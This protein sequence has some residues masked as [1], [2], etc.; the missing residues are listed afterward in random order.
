MLNGVRLLR[1][2]VRKILLLSA[3]LVIAL[4][5]LV[6]AGRETIDE[7]DRYRSSINSYA[8]TLLGLGLDSQELQ[9]EW[10]QLT[11]R[12][13][14]KDLSIYG[15]DQQKPAIT[16]DYVTLDLDLIQSV[17]SRH[18]VWRELQLGRVNLTAREDAEG[19]WTIAGLPLSGSGD[20]SGLLDV[21]F[22][23]AYLEIELVSLSLVFF[24]GTEEVLEARNILLE[25]SGGFH[26]LLAAVNLAGTE[27][28]AELIVEGRGDRRDFKNF[29]G[30]GYLKLNRIDFSGS[31]NAL[32]KGWFP[33][34]VERIGNIET[35]IKGEVW[36]NLVEGGKANLVGRISAAEVPLNWLED[37]AP[38]TNFKTEMTGWFHL[39][40]DWGLRLQGLDFDWDE[41]KIEPLD[42]NFRQAVGA[43][44]DNGSLAVSQINLSLLDDLLVKA[45][46]APDAIVDIVQQLQPMGNINS[47]HLDLSL[48]NETPDVQMRANLDNVSVSSWRGA[49]AIRH[50][51]GY[52]EVHNETGFVE[53][54]SPDG[55]AL[56]YPQVFDD[57]MEHSAIRGQVKWRWDEVS[58][59]VKVSS[60]PLE[61]GGEE[62]LGRAYFYLDLP[63]GQTE[64]QPDDKPEMYLS[65]GVNNTH[66]R[67]RNRYLPK[68]L[69]VGLLD[70]LDQSVGD[71]SIPEMGF[72][73]RGALSGGDVDLHSLQLYLNLADG[74]LKF[75]SDWPALKQ[76]DAVLTLDDKELDAEINTAVLG[77][78][79]VKHSEVRVRPAPE[80]KGLELLIG[81]DIDADIGDAINVLAQ[82]PLKSRVEGL[83]GWDISGDSQI[84]LDLT[85]PL[86]AGAAGGSYHV[87][88]RLSQVRMALPDSEFAFEQLQGVLSYRNGKGLFSREIKGRFWDEPMIASLVTKQDNLSVDI[89]G[90]LSRSVLDKFLNLSLDQVFQGKTDVQANVLVP[91]ED[92]T[93]PL[94]LTMNSQLQG[95]VINLPAPFGKELDSRRGITSTV[96]FSDHLDIEVSMGEG[97]QAHLIQKDGVLVRGLLALDSKQTALPEV[98]QFMV[99]G[100]LEH[101]SLSEWQSAVSPL[102]SDAGDTID[103]D[104][105]LK[106]VFDIKIDELDVAGLSVEQ[107]MVTGRYQDEGWQ[108]GVNSDLVAGQILIPQDTA[109]PMVL[110]L[111]RLSLPTPTEAGGDADA[112]DPMSLPHLQLSVKNFS[113]GN[114]L[115]GEASFLMEPQSNGVRI[116]GIDANLL[117]LQVGGEEYDTSLEWTLEDGRHRTLVDGLLRAG[118]LG[119][120]MEAWGL[121]EILDSDEAHFFTEM[122][123]PG[124]PW[125]ISTTTMKGTMSLQLQKGR[126]Y[127]A[128]KGATKQ[129]IRLISLFNFDNWMRRLRLDFS[130]LFEEGM[131]YD[132]M[133]GGLIFDEGT[134]TFDAPIVVKLPS[135]RVRLEGVADLISE[136][137]DAHLVTTLPFGTNLPW[138]VAL[139]GGLPAAAGVYVT[140]KLFKKQVD[141]LSSISYRITG[142]WNDPEIVVERVFSD[143][144]SSNKKSNNKS[145]S[146]TSDSEE[147]D[148]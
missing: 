64:G 2:I 93:S 18:V 116:S 62:G 40:E 88:T 14:A 22:D 124:R 105:S 32:A 128:P 45:R 56:H 63:F 78:A 111:E 77:R 3:F 48:E 7:L 12:I 107:A 15:P 66:S 71:T 100:H 57:Y 36:I 69:S 125:E 126:F 91:L 17:L 20:S 6:S 115:F 123:W 30:R 117:G 140:G 90:R 103:S 99:T 129:M 72:I 41:L 60:G 4:A 141:K 147:S 51:N 101:F 122:T 102:L 110:D 133:H 82:S 67:Y 24:S 54:D 39:G 73:W 76:L 83:L 9:G 139:A 28:S 120:V 131:S 113:V 92:S 146:S 87:D 59:S 108:I 144:T 34:I 145:G 89:N 79:H 5:L 26:R 127:Q 35:D 98:G 19:N 11:P 43:E 8:S 109:S 61:F 97:I 96:E 132:E 143:S 112:L 121:P 50:I 74:N 10:H 21:L 65:V 95:V 80:G 42:I 86:S 27:Q 23:S 114:K 106:P 137:I 130:D 135:G 16:L 25:N 85:I 94:R 58:S 134:L 70:W 47:L 52:I 13:T 1:G 53:L 31:L 81:G 138:I 37:V 104:E 33:E 136:D 46:L 118:D 148:Q 44:W 29:D 75:H 38:L 84:N 49:P 142:S 119:D 55:F 68:N